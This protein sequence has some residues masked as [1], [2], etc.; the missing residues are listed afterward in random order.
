MFLDTFLR[1]NLPFNLDLLPQ[2]SYLVGGAVRDILLNRS[3]NYLDLD[4]VLPNS[5]IKIAKNIANIYDAGFVV[6]DSE[7]H[8]ARVVFPHATIDFAQQEGDSIEKDLLR[9]DYTINAIA[10]HCHKKIIID[11]LKGEEDLSQ[12]I[13]KMICRQNLKD[14][15]LRLLRAYRQACQLNFTIE[16]DTRQAI[17]ELIPLL[18][19]VATERVNNE[20]SYLLSSEYGSYWLKEAF[21]D[22]LLSLYWHNINEVKINYLEKIDIYIKYLKEKFSYFNDVNYEN[23]NS[24]KLAC[25]TDS[26]I[27]IAQQELLNLKYS[28]QEIKAVITILKYTPS[29]SEK[30]F[31]SNLSSQYFFFLAVGKIFPNVVIFALA[32]GISS[33]LITMLIHR[34]IDNQDSVA[35]PQ[36]LLTGN[37][38]MEFLKIP[39]SPLIKQL[40]TDVQ[41]AYIEGKFSDKNGALQWI[42]DYRL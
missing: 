21:K 30:D 8:I 38:L 34:Y 31:Y 26:N 14:D 37:D 32:D 18:K 24:A 1:D 9:R 10:Y 17:Q 15:P 42:I 29:L 3:R 13:I 35:H 5:V 4:F 27:E 41:I 6:L 19:N 40:L 20:L 16:S 28:R 36:P 12:G 11:S 33:D 22:G 23:F 39:P 25:L 2:N 7:R